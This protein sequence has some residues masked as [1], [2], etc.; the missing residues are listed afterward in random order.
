[1]CI[2]LSLAWQEEKMM[3]CGAVPYA[4]LGAR[5]P[6]PSTVACDES[7]NRLRDVQPMSL[8]TSY[9]DDGDE[10]KQHQSGLGR[11]LC[12]AGP[13]APLITLLIIDTLLSNNHTAHH[14][15]L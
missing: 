12:V 1:V 14:N 5:S 6:Q 10:R 2:L 4:N 9:G 7:T 13:V 8:V 11:R 15:D 3:C